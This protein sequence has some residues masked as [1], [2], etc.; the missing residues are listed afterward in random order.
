MYKLEV[1]RSFLKDLERIDSRQQRIILVKMNAD[2]NGTENPRSFG[3]ELK[4]KKKGF[5]RY[6]YGNYRVIAKIDDKELIILALQVGRRQDIY[7]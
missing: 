7:K 3:K 6:R 5:W 2:L 4:G 1:T